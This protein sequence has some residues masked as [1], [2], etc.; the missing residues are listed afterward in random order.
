M[1]IIGVRLTTRRG[2]HG[3]C[4][5][6]SKDQT[7]G[8]IDARSFIAL[9]GYGAPCGLRPVVGDTWQRRGAE[10]SAELP[11]RFTPSIAQRAARPSARRGACSGSG[12][13]PRFFALRTR[14]RATGL[15]S[16]DGGADSALVPFGRIS[17]SFSAAPR[18]AGRPARAIASV[19]APHRRAGEHVRAASLLLLRRWNLHSAPRHVRPLYDE[20]AQMAH[21]GG[22]LNRCA[23]RLGQHA[24]KRTSFNAR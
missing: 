22:R 17:A 16:S 13:N 5:P 24:A 21:A 19:G 10:L 20:L 2:A 12:P 23:A 18:R 8:W 1:P 6:V 11:S 4:R 7:G 15:A 14:R 9:R 3:V